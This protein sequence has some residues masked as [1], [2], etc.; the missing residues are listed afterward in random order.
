MIA[1]LM[2]ALSKMYKKP[3]VSII[4]IIIIIYE[5]II[6]HEKRLMVIM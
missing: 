1:D 5:N 3:F 2:V 6:Q 4:I